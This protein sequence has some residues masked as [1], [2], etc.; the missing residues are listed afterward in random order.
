MW[1]VLERRAIKSKVRRSLSMVN[2]ATAITTL[3]ITQDE[4]EYLKKSRYIDVEDPR[5]ITRIMDAYNLMG[6]TI[7]DES[8]EVCKFLYDDGEG[9]YEVITF[10]GLEREQRDNT[11]KIVNLMSKMSR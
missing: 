3:A 2:D 4:V 6:F 10:D 5:I 11:K 1:K 9:H 7:V 8:M